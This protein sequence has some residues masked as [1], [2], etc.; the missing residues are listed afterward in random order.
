MM[1]LLQYFRK[2]A[3]FQKGRLLWQQVHVIV[4]IVVVAVFQRE[5]LLW[6]QVYHKRVSSQW[7]W[8]TLVEGH[9]HHVE[10]GQGTA[11]YTFLTTVAKRRLVLE[12]NLDVSPINLVSLVHMNVRLC[13]HTICASVE[14]LYL[15]SPGNTIFC[16]WIKRL[17]K[18]IFS[19]HKNDECMAL[20]YHIVL[21]LLRTISY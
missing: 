3:V 16:D 17:Y 4:L 12:H 5:R 21:D 6:Q 19:S 20:S 9:A 10:S 11:A 8:R 15:R 2:V 14:L 18:S 13:R 1:L 7:S